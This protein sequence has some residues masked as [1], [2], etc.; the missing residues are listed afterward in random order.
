M[1]WWI[2][3]CIVLGGLLL[4]TFVI[5][6]YCFMRVFYSPKRQPV[7][8]DEY[9]IPDGEIYEEYR[10]QMTEWTKAIRAMPH[11]EMSIQSFDGLTLRGN[12]Y[13]YAKGAPIEILFHGYQ[14]YAE[15]DLCAA[16]ERCFALGRSVILVN[17][18]SSGT[19]DGRV[20]TFGIRERKDCVAWTRY[21]SNRF[22]KDIK[23]MIGG[24]S[25]GAATV[26]MAADED[27]PENVVCIMGDCGYTSAQDIIKKIIK[28]MRLPADMVYPFVKLGAKIFGGFNL[29]ETSP[30]QAVQKSKKPVILLHGD[31]DAFVPYEMSERIYKACTSQKKLVKIEGAGHGLAYPKNPEKYLQGLRDFESECGF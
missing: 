29:D 21:V 11:E 17:Q 23:I 22:G 10:E 19:S 12:Y 20:I 24:V 30:I 6:F 18:R 15:R 5:A 4:L 16:V 2:W 1:D 14:G 25:M 7:G 8:E 26:L 28:E 13:E 3:V 9:P 31:T 27:L